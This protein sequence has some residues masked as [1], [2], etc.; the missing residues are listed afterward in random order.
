MKLGSRFQRTS[1][2]FARSNPSSAS[3]TICRGSL[4]K[5]RRALALSGLSDT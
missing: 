4:T 2:R 3:S 1:E 5:W